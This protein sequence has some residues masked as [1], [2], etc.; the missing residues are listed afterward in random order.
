MSSFGLRAT[1]A[2]MLK[3]TLT[4]MLMCYT[5]LPTYLTFIYG[6]ALILATT[7]SGMLTNTVELVAVGGRMNT[8][9][10]TC[11]N[12]AISCVNNAVIR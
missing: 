10:S 12:G 7:L 6:L 1:S 3:L 11:E 5:N 9:S 8:L 4:Y 2:T